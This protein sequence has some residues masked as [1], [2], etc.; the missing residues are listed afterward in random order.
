MIAGSVGSLESAPLVAIRQ[1]NIELWGVGG[2]ESKFWSG[3][4]FLQFSLALLCVLEGV[5]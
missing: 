5:C 2:K 4:F 1:L 3:A